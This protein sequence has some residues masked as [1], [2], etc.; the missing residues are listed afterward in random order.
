M[1]QGS[2]K[3][4]VPAR[5]G[6]ALA[7]AT[8]TTGI[9]ATPASAITHNLGHSAEGKILPGQYLKNGSYQFIMQTDGNLVLYG[10]SHR[11][12]WASGTNGLKGTFV[13]Y[14]DHKLTP[15]DVTLENASYGRL[16][17]WRGGYEWLHKNG[18][19]SLNDK[20]E[21]WIAWKKWV[22]C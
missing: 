10:P 21:V 3:R 16:G 8:L 6:L 19:L 1:T 7:A 17:H 9:A 5:V 2:R 20:G 15:P 22:H 18:N 4:R 13:V 12:C 11:V 14:R